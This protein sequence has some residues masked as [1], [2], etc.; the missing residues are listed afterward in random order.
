MVFVMNVSVMVG[1]G[2]IM[3]LVLF[4]CVGFFFGFVY[5]RLIGVVI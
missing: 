5:M 1:F 2:G 3:I 4:M